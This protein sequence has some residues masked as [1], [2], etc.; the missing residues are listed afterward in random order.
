MRTQ[1]KKCTA[2]HSPLHSVYPGASTEQL[3]SHQ[4]SPDGVVDELEGECPQ[5]A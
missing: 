5:L 3:L 1:N 4:I 2:S